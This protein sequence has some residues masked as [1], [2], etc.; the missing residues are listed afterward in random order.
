MKYYDWVLH[1]VK[2]DFIFLFLDK[3]VDVSNVAQKN[4]K[5]QKE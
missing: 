2:L 3:M 4:T 1:F 5:R